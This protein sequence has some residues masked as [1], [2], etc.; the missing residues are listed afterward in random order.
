M[1]PRKVHDLKC[2]PEPF[3]A[4]LDGRKTVEIRL[5]DR[6][7]QVGDRLIL[8][9]FDPEKEHVEQPTEAESIS[10]FHKPRP[11]TVRG[12]FTG[13]ACAVDVTHVLAGGQFGLDVDYV[14][15]SVRLA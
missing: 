9:E 2:W 1:I 10:R 3:A 7:Y 13:R 6:D 11:Y 4:V 8:R 5:N 15:L 14:A 12:T